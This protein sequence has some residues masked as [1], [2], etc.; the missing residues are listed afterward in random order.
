IDSVLGRDLADLGF[1]SDQNRLDQSL[2][3]RVDRAF[4]RR[5]LARVRDRGGY[6]FEHLASLEELF[7][8]AGS[9]LCSHDVLA[10]RSAKSSR[11]V[12]FRLSLGSSLA[13]RLSLARSAEASRYVCLRL[14]LGSRLALRLSLARSA[15]ASRYVCF[16]LSL[17]SS[18]ALRLS[19]A[20]SAE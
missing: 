4:E 1:G 5:L 12:C 6:R 16:R 19:L 3:A 17:G 14:S 15:E 11:Y 13:L 9:C 8:F 10:C 18:L 7:V 20:R 2:L